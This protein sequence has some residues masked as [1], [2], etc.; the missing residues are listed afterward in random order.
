[1]EKR[2]V[3]DQSLVAG[4]YRSWI[5]VYRFK[6]DIYTKKKEDG[7]SFP[8]CLHVP[9][10]TFPAQHRN[11][12]STFSPLQFITFNLFS[13][14]RA[15]ARMLWCSSSG[16]L[17]LSDWLLWEI[18]QHRIRLRRCIRQH[19]PDDEWKWKN[20]YENFSFSLSRW[21]GMFINSIFELCCNNFQFCGDMTVRPKQI[22][23][24]CVFFYEKMFLF[25]FMFRLQWSDVSIHAVVA[26]ENNSSKN[27][28]AECVFCER[29]CGDD[30]KKYAKIEISI[31]RQFKEERC[32][33]FIYIEYKQFCSTINQ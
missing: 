15:L 3:L 1:M 32:S 2:A 13:S 11:M 26:V 20:I 33:V 10:H 24:L 5:S 29:V 17:P 23:S 7:K 30:R 18:Q 12:I 25:L 4:V 6:I 19:W 16:S 28:S 31:T 22:C 21:E 8:S 27:P 14:V 9:F